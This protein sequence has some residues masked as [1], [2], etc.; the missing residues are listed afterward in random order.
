MIVVY[1]ETDLVMHPV[2][3]KMINVKWKLFAR[4]KSIIELVINFIYTLVWVILALLIP[5]DGKFH[6]PLAS[7]SW[8]IVLE[9]IFFFLTVYFAFKVCFTPHIEVQVDFSLIYCI[10]SLP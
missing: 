7:K 6:T 3:Q 2:I 4:K 9:A 1:R 5:R 8:R 10:R